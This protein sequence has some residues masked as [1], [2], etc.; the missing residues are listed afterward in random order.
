MSERTKMYRKLTPNER[1][2][3]VLAMANWSLSCISTMGSL[4]ILSH[5]SWYL[6][7]PG[8]ATNN[9]DAYDIEL[10]FFGITLD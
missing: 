5:N 2:D 9:V 3:W 7:H 10:N 4:H 6:D 8:D 1:Y